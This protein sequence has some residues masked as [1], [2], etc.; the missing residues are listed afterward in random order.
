MRSI[1]RDAPLKVCL[2]NVRDFL[3]FMVSSMD[4]LTTDLASPWGKAKLTWAQAEAFAATLDVSAL[5]RERV[6]R[7]LYEFAPDGMVR[8]LF[9]GALRQVLE[10]NAGVAQANALVAAHGIPKRLVAFSLYHHRDFYK[11]WFAAIPFAHRGAGISIGMERIAETFFPVWLESTAGRTMALLLG[12]D[13]ITIT[14]RL[15]DAYAV[16]VPHNDHKVEVLGDGRVRWIGKVEPSPYFIE[17]FRGIVT[18]TMRSQNVSVPHCQGH[19]EGPV[20]PHHQ[21]VVFDLSWS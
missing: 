20:G 15:R 8:G 14:R 5:D 1:P 13:P 3:A 10:H 17:T 6:A 18:G 4:G 21:Q 9:F 16:S 19:I 11:F 7:T 12:K 2:V